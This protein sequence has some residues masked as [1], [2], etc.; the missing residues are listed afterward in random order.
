MRRLILTIP[1]TFLSLGEGQALAEQVASPSGKIAANVAVVEGRLMFAIKADGEAIIET[2]PMGFTMNGSD[3]GSQVALGAATSKLVDETFPS[4]HGV[5]SQ[6]RN[7]YRELRVP[8]TH[9][10]TGESYVLDVRAYDSGIAFR[11]EFEGGGA[12]NIT[13]EATGFVIPAHTQVFAQGDNAIYEG[14]YSGTAID[15]IADGT[16]MG[17]PVIGRLAGGTLHFAITHSGPGDGFPNPFLTKTSGRLLQNSYPRNGDGSFGGSTVQG[18]CGPW[19]VITAGS[20]ETLVNSD[21]V[22]GVA[23]PPDPALFPKGAATGWI[24]SGRSVW[25]WMSRFPGGITAK[26]AKLA[27]QWASRLGFEYNTI[28]DGWAAWNGGNPWPELEDVVKASNAV[29]VKVLVWTRSEDIRTADQRKEF[30][31]RLEELGVSGFKADFF[32]FHK[33]S[34]AAKERVELLELILKDAAQHHL[35]VDLHGTGKPLG[36]FRTYPNLLNIEGVHGKEYYLD[37]TSTVYAPL[38]RLLAGP[39]DYTPLGL[40][41]KLKGA[42]TQAFEIAS[43]ALM[44]GPLITYAERGDR[45]AHSPFAPVI[46]HIPCLWDETRVLPGTVLGESC[47]MARRNGTDWY[48]AIMNVGTARSWELDLSFLKDGV[49]Y[50]AEIVRDKATSLEHRIVNSAS[51]IEVLTEDKGGF[52]MH[53]SAPDSEPVS[54]LPFQ[55]SFST[56]RGTLYA[57]NGEV[58]S[59]EPW[60]SRLLADRLP[61]QLWKITGEGLVPSLDTTDAWRGGSSLK[62]EGTLDEASDLDLFQTDLPLSATTRLAT[63]FKLGRAGGAHAKIGLRF[64]D[65]PRSPTFLDIPA[66]AAA[67]WE[68]RTFDLGQFSGRTLSSIFLR[69]ES[70]AAVANYRFSL[71]HLEI[72]EGA[73]TSPSAPADFR[74]EELEVLGLETLSAVLSWSAAPGAVSHYLIYQKDPVAERTKWLGATSGVSFSV[75]T[76][77]LGDATESVFEIV[78]VG[79][80]GGRSQ[81]LQTKRIPL[82]D[83]PGLGEALSGTVI[84]TSGAFQDSGNTRD[85]AFDSDAATFFDA[86]MASGAWV[87]IEVAATGASRVGG[88]RVIPREGW[89]GRMVGGV[90]EGANRDDFSDAVTLAS[91]DSEPLEG[92][93]TLIPV[94]EESPFRYLRYLS[95][96]NG[97]CNVAEVVFYSAG[98][99]VVPGG[100]GRAR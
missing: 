69:F 56:G 67:G 54:K 42:Q 94:K 83:L 24:S 96:A 97:S 78:A 72:S 92:R 5:H 77:R 61:D 74:A 28:D 52:V 88:V 33:V 58:L 10:P 57:E 39:A 31:S 2:S 25:D 70:Q 95:P 3:R 48:V 45:I 47:A 46:T 49:S 16:V 91:I 37:A 32:D 29:G 27:S 21:I 30:F 7:H 53:L 13:S 81:R 50:Q 64:A 86:P 82:P 76:D 55:S 73:I 35:M 75:T 38:A 19:N 85:K 4:R 87:G 98:T 14:A 51:R 36:Q 6:V 80:N 66:A 43:A 1:L 22:E 62:V 90:F 41:G 23:P 40:E 8:V 68:K 44:A 71:G 18:G 34:P 65:A 93:S 99:P 79:S 26:N 63:A 84:G 89:A 100:E 17:P 60:E 11:Y 59:T 15:N 20:L 12:K 9:G